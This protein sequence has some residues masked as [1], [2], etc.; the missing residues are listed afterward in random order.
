[1]VIKLIQ[2]LKHIINWSTGAKLFYGQWLFIS[3]S[4][5]YGIFNL[6]YYRLI[7]NTLRLY[8]R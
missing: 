5:F 3:S 1:M 8:L 4:M 6:R 2:Y 7:F